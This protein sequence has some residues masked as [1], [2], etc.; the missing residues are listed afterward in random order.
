MARADNGGKGKSGSGSTTDTSIIYGTRGDDLF[1]VN[2]IGVLISERK[3]GGTDTVE[4]S[5]DFTL[6]D[7]VENLTLVGSDP[8]TGD[9][10]DLDNLLIGNTGDNYLSGYAGNDILEGGEGNDTL[11]GGSGTDTAVYD[12]NYEDYQI[13]AT[14]EGVIVTS[15]ADGEILYSDLLVNVEILRFDDQDVLVSDLNSGGAGAETSPAPPVANEDY[16]TIDE[17]SPISISPLANDFGDGLVLASVGGAL[18]GTV[19]IEADGTITYTPDLNATGSDSFSY[20]VMDANGETATS[21]VHL[22]IIATNDLPEANGEIYDLTS[23]DL[24]TSAN[25]LLDNDTDADGDTL[26]I[27]SYDTVTANGGTVVIDEQGGFTYQVPLLYADSSADQSQDTFTYTVSDGMGGTATATVVLNMSVSTDPSP[28]PSPEPTGPTVPDYVLEALLKDGAGETDFRWDPEVPRG[29]AIT[30]TYSFLESVPDYYGA[31]APERTD[32][33]PL[34]E[35]QR[36]AVLEALA[37]IESFTN[38]TFVEVTYGVGDLAFGTADFDVGSAWAYGPSGAEFGLSG[39]VWL[40]NSVNHDYSLGGD[41]MKTLMHEIGHALGMDHPGSALPIAESNAQFTIMSYAE[42]KTTGGIEPSSYMVY[43]IAALQHLYGANTTETA[44][45][46]VYVVSGLNDTVMTI[47]D[48]GGW[49][50]LDASGSTSSVTLNLN[51]GS[52]SSAG[53]AY[54]WYNITNNI[55]LAYNTYIEEAVGGAG[56]DTLIG[57]ALDNVL[58]GNDGKDYFVF[59]AD[60]GDDLITDFEDG[61]DMIDIRALGVGFD[62]LVIGEQNGDAVV[63]YGDSSITLSGVAPGE[64]DA[65]DLLFDSIA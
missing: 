20:T 47:W 64:L 55:G 18:H 35:E 6:P 61:I 32:F 33:Q 46:D 14:P 2:E 52:F 53:T 10:N 25:S 50:V 8:L 51:P 39:D 44:G 49:D 15:F 16:A 22:E 45:D 60:W 37:Q 42:H 23:F 30:L 7:E 3:N 34:S 19:T 62:D 31:N 43:D 29:T 11:D 17:D 5:V 24:F 41:G 12:G 57:N 63:S 4:S 59:E 40:D 54:G 21:T 36:A 1:I 58:T 48:S 26:F 56:N 13:E 28:E 38:I 65:G 9:G 27:V